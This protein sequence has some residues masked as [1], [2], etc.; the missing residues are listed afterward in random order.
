MADLT[1]RLAR[2][3]QENADLRA[4]LEWLENPA[5]KVVAPRREDEGVRVLTFL[6]QA[7]TNLPDEDQARALLKIICARHPRLRW[8]YDRWLTPD[9]ELESFRAALAFICSLTKTEKP[10]TRYALSWWIDTGQQWCR[11]A[12]VLGTIRSLLPAIIGCNNVPYCLEDR[13][14]LW[15]DPFR[16]GQ[17]VDDQVWRRLLAGGDLIAPTKVEV[18]ADHTIGLQRVQTAW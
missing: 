1:S 3:E 12:G 9:D 15:L 5:P 7:S 11:E 10:V 8:K 13:E 2:L 6:P 14:T 4:R 17:A 16:R 18:I